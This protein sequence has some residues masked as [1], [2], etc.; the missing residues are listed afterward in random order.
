MCITIRRPDSH[1]KEELQKTFE[2]QEDAQIIV[3]RR[4]TERRTRIQPVSVG[5]R[6]AGRR[7]VKEELVEVVL[8]A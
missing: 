5:H 4:Y 7:R 2:D 8:L 1:L 6:L 3:D